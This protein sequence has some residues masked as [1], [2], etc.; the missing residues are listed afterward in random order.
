MGKPLG[1]LEGSVC[2]IRVRA[3]RALGEAHL[4]RSTV[5]LS[6]RVYPHR[7]YPSA[8]PRRCV[9]HRVKLLG[10]GEVM[11][12]TGDGCSA[13]ISPESRAGPWPDSPFRW[14]YGKLRGNLRGTLHCF[15]LAKKHFIHTGLVKVQSGK[16]CRHAHPPSHIGDI[17]WTAS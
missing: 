11:L 12:P 13:L 8:V 4:R 17:A 5:R 9:R 3:S 7:A 15:L 1:A 16:S 14:R 10:N 2:G 6:Q